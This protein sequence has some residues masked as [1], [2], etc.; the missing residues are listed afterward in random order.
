MLEKLCEIVT[1]NC[2]LKTD[3]S[4]TQVMEPTT[5][6]FLKHS[7][8]GKVNSLTE[9]KTRKLQVQQSTLP[10]RKTYK[11]LHVSSGQAKRQ[12]GRETT[13]L[14]RQRDEAVNE[15]AAVDYSLGKVTIAGK[16]HSVEIKGSELKDGHDARL[17]PPVTGLKRRAPQ[18][19]V[20]LAA[21]NARLV[22]DESF[23]STLKSLIAPLTSLSNLTKRVRSNY[24]EFTQETP[25][26]SGS[27]LLLKRGLVKQTLSIKHFTALE[28]SNQRTSRGVGQNE[29]FKPCKPGNIEMNAA[30]TPSLTV[31]AKKALLK[32]KHREKKNLNNEN[33]TF[34]R[35]FNTKYNNYKKKPNLFTPP[36]ITTKVNSS[37]TP[38]IVCFNRGGVTPPLCQCGRRTRRRSVVNPGPNQGRAFFTCSLSH[39]RL[40]HETNSADKKAKRGCSFFRW[41]V[42]L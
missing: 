28:H 10:E 22:S 19:I 40:G 17:L 4:A 39:G 29:S 24:G 15:K 23:D 37:V 20:G 5:G 13:G 33:C 34:A 2:Y 32:E 1:K 8:D 18:N 14:G 26:S 35:R 30:T 25:K 36:S 11:S 41:E 7:Y 21:A 9:A 31:Q 38:P 16:D 42:N 27:G 3:S 12:S 6:T